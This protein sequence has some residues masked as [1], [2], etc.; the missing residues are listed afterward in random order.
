MPDES[1]NERLV[2]ALLGRR[3]R[4]DAMP[5]AH[6][7]RPMFSF[8]GEDAGMGPGDIHQGR[9]YRIYLD[10][11]AERIITAAQVVVE[12]ELL[13]PCSGYAR[14]TLDRFDYGPVLRW[15]LERTDPGTSWK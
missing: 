7:G 4:P 15:C 11:D 6:A 2:Q 1:Y 5:K 13:S 10:Y 14:E 8:W 9:A 12:G 3:L